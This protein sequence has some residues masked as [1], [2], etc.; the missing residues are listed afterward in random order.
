V[1]KLRSNHNLFDQKKENAHFYVSSL[2]V[3]NDTK[4]NVDYSEMGCFKD[5]V[6]T[7]PSQLLE[8]RF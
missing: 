2:V 8:Q 1:R 5:N 4:T 3:L 7:T 6:K